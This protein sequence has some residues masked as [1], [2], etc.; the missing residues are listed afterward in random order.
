MR[1]RDRQPYA[2]TA[3]SKGGGE[4]IQRGQIRWRKEPED[5]DYPAA[6]RY[7]RLLYDNPTT[8]SCVKR[9]RRASMVEFKAKDI[10][11]ASGWSL[12]GISNSHVEKDR[13]S[14]RSRRALSP[15]LLVRMRDHSKIII[16]DGYHRLC[17]VYS[18]D[19]D[20]LIPCKI[21]SS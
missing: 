17:V 4:M 5:H 2:G 16:A 15:L 21:V 6:E 11:Q 12:L 14:I 13:A 9:L 8:A 10:F 18:F 7:L 1:A 3:Y 19:G 20:A